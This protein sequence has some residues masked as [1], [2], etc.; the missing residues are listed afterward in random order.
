MATWT[1]TATNL[2]ERLQRM[3]R[4]LDELALHMKT[5]ERYPM[6][7]DQLREEVGKLKIEVEEMREE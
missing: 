4:R 6:E 7:L 2:E 3:E 5:W 1:G